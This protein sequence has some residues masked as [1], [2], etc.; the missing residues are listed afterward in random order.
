MLAISSL[1]QDWSRSALRTLGFSLKLWSGLK[2]YNLKLS[3]KLAGINI[4]Y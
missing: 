2:T 1:G 4:N 3:K